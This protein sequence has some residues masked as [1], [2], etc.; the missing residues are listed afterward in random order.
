MIGRS[1]IKSRLTD[2]RKCVVGAFSKANYEVTL[3]PRSGDFGRDVIAIRRG[4]GCVKIIGSVK[5]YAAGNL[6]PYDDIRA[7][8]GVM[9]G[10]RTYQR[11]SSRP[12]R[13][14]TPRQRR[15]RFIIHLSQLGLS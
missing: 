9:A 6:V 8:L 13:I 1:R 10:E 15:S 11:A 14:S 12:R 3:T 2:G 5:R 7:L 4:V